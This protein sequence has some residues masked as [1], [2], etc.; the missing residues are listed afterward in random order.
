MKKVLHLLFFLKLSILFSQ[1]DINYS[2]EAKF[3]EKDGR[4]DINQIISFKNISD[5]TVETIYMND[6]ANSYSN[7]DTP[8]AKRFGEEYD[9]SFYLSSKNKLGFTMIDYVKENGN[10]INWN[11]LS[12]QKDIIRIILNRPLKKNDSVNINLKY[13]VKLPDSKFTG[14]GSKNSE[15]FNLKYW[16]ISISPFFNGEWKKY[17]N[18]DL[19]DSSI[20]SANYKLSLDV[21]KDLSVKINLEK[22]GE[23][24][25]IN[26]KR[27]IK[28]FHGE[29][30]KE[31]ELVLSYKNNFKKIIDNEGKSI[32]TDVYSKNL[33]EKDLSENV[34]QIIEFVNS[35]LETENDKTTLVSKIVYEKNPYYGLNDLPSFLRP[36]SDDFLNEISFLKAYLHYFLS[37]KLT[38]DLRENHWILTGLQ[39]YIIIKYIEKFHPNQKFLGR[40]SSLGIMKLYN[41]STVDFNDSFL[42]YSEFVK[43]ANLQQADVTPKNELT[44]FNEQIASPYHIGLGFRYLE[45]YLGETIFKKGIRKFIKNPINSSLRA[46]IASNTKEDLSWFF[47]DYIG[48]RESFDLSIKKSEIKDNNITIE[49]INKKGAKFPYTIGQLR[50][51][52]LVDL[53]WINPKNNTTEITLKYLD[54]DYISINPSLRLP[55]INR[56]NNWRYIKRKNKPVQ[57]NFFKDYESPKRHQIYYNPI[58]NYNYYDGF[59]IGSRFH[60]KGIKM[61]KFT[62]ELMPEYSTNQKTIVGAIKGQLNLLNEKSENYRTQ[63]NLYASSY[64]YKLNSRY[65]VIV[66]G[67]STFIRTPDFRSNKG[68]IFSL[69]YYSV[70]RE[71]L[72]DPEINPNYNILSAKY[73]YFNKTAIKHFTVK[74]NL[75]VSKGFGKIDFTTNYR[76]LFPSGRQISGRLFIGKFLWHNRTDTSYFDYNLNS[77]TD[78]LFN[79]NYFGRSEEQG[80]FSQQ[81]IMAEGGFKS[82]FETSSAN[83][84]IISSNFTIGLWKFIEMY[85]DI[86]VIK[87]IGSSSTGFFDSGLGLNFIPDYLQLFFPLYTSNG[88]QINSKSYEE[89]IRFVLSI[90]PDQLMSLFSRRWF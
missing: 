38:I 76:K 74:S 42:L 72:K 2:I 89:K 13:S 27:V 22:T 60:N 50:N 86:G 45:E 68:Q 79:Y 16:Y 6:W 37:S 54:S 17:S 41:I 35:F 31:I 48:K 53:R 21:L 80:I 85:S 11:R 43:R 10:E 23:K 20:S 28:S 90:D 34:I 29:N 51:D 66:P 44:R 25:N 62:F 77:P 56:N 69:F 78:Y 4:I 83:S 15:T 64:H 26:G 7:T 57:F 3:Y 46:S 67:I 87:N 59:S 49:V 32:I 71:N 75:E 65:R 24:I 47:D 70:F 14:Y 40:I 12:N 58:M 9:R 30:K 82:K 33:K 18:L 36:F 84:Y 61:Q 8:L 1:V 88:W 39:T 52:S 5:N 81:F 55:E 63:I 73:L 19:D